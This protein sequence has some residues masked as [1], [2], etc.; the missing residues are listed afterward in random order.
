[1]L[2]VISPA[3]RLD[4]TGFDELPLAPDRM[5]E[6]QFQKEADRLAAHARQLSVA[7][8]QHLMGISANLA[9]LNRDRYQAMR[10]GIA[11]DDRRPAVFAFAG[12][13]YQGLHAR[14]LDP[15]TM[16]YAQDN[17]RILSG[18]YGLLRPLDAIKPYRLEMGSALKSRRG[19]DLY[20]FWGS[21]LARELNRQAE[22]TGARALVNCASNEYFS[23][24]DPAVLSLNIVTP[25]FLERKSGGDKI[26]SFFA[27][28]AR[29][30]MA[31][32]ILERR[33]T[34]PD[35]LCDFDSGGYAYVPDA[36]TP[37][38]PVFRRVH[39]GA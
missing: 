27:K 39:P 3:K 8:I 36:S 30:A 25:V 38:R 31:R 15:D 33:V 16:R 17:L 22:R 2:V 28:K 32:Y 26:I 29:G 13:T 18:L 1:M 4:W 19:G 14:D 11:D 37:E 23:A 34:D 5:S 12:D 6:P 7:Q 24:V 10:P 35:G 21:H 20:Q 9:R